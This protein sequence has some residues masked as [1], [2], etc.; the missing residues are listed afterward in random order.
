MAKPKPLES[1]LVASYAHT[2]SLTAYTNCPAE[3]FLTYVCD[4]FDSFTHC[5]NKFTKK[6]DGSYNKDSEDSLR[7]IS[8]AI[9]GTL[10]GHFETF[11]KSLF[12]GLVERSNHF[13]EFTPE[14]FLKHFDK[15]CGGEI[16]ISVS[17][18]L[19][20]RGIQA[21]VGFVIAD[22]LKGWHNPSGVNSFF[23]AFGIQQ[24][25][26]SNG[27]ISD[28]TVLWQL[29]HS[30]VHTGAW[31][32]L[33]DSQKVKRLINYGDKPI[34]FDTQF[35]NAV[36]RRLHKIVKAANGRLLTDCTTLLGTSPP[37]SVTQ[38]FNAFLAVKSPKN[39]WL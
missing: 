32:T 15:N 25:L 14:K 38:D 7:H 6:N 34:V 8:C 22:S 27:E 5:L 35:I 28:L 30:I 3:A 19:A 37:S 23:K 33:P 17:R 21:S 36:C 26:F 10:M 39:N 9:L 20:F 12:A 24:N 13:S 18:L 2:T 11:E 31:L 1:Y 16:S 29:R 4:A